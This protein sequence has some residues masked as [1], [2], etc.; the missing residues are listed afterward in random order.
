MDLV[1]LGYISTVLLVLNIVL[2]AKGVLSK[3]RPL[4]LFAMYLIVIGLIELASVY[5]AKVKHE[6]NLHLSHLYFIAQFI[7]LSF[8]YERLI[9]FRII[10]W[11]L[12]VVLIV[13][14][15][16]YIN[17]PQLISEYNVI[18]MSLT[19]TLIV[20]YSVMYFYAS[21]QADK[22]FLIVN[23]GIFLYLI[24][25]TL[26]FASGNVILKLNLPDSTQFTLININ[27]VLYVLFQILIF[28]EWYKNYRIKTS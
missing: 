17:N 3:N 13:L 1:W 23:I 16:Q 20:V 5:V 21:L 22:G 9:N 10:R 14:M 19:H 18:G 25:S 26:I 24:S 8:F 6:P 7:L 28:M 15:V 2:F 4:Q 12:G 27:R 11:I